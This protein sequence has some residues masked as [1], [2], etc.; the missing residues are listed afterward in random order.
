[1]FE[2]IIQIVMGTF[3]TGNAQADSLVYKCFTMKTLVDRKEFGKWET[4]FNNVFSYR[5]TQSA[6]KNDKDGF[7]IIDISLLD[8]KV[9]EVFK[10]STV[11]STVTTK[12]SNGFTIETN[13]AFDPKKD[14]VSLPMTGELIPGLL[15]VFK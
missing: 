1:M 11:E 12:T 6:V 13:P 10:Y 7:L 9:V 5:F 15:E 2:K 3:S 14:I 4:G 8:K